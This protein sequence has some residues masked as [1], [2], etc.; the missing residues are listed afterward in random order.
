MKFAKTL[1]VASVLL[2]MANT[3]FASKIEATDEYDFN[4]ALQ[5]VFHNNV[6]SIVLVTSGGVY[7]TQDTVPM[8]I[9]K[10]LTI[11]AAPG[12]AEKPIITHSDPDSNVL[13][14]FYVCNDLTVEGV[15][16]DGGHEQCHGM[17]Y[18]LRVQH[19][20]N[21]YPGGQKFV[22]IGT[23]LRVK[24][25]DF[26]NII[27]DKQVVPE[28]NGGHALYFNRPDGQN[29]PTIKAGTIVFENC[30]FHRIGDEA[31]RLTET[32]KYPIDRV[33]DTL[34][35]RNCT[36][37]DVD[38]ECIRF[39]A[40]TDETT[41]DAYVMLENLTINNCATRV[42]Y[43]KNNFGTTFRNVI[44]TNSRLPGISRLDRTDFLVQIQRPGSHICCV[45]SF[46]ITTLDGTDEGTEIY[47]SKNQGMGVDEHTIYGF[48]PMYADAATMDYTLQAA[49][50][51]YF[52]ASDNGPLGD[53]RWATNA[54]T[55]IAFN[56]TKT[57]DG[58]VVCDPPL[59]GRSF[60][61]GTQATVTAAPDSAWTFAGWGGDLAGSDNPVTVDVN[62]A[63]NFSVTFESSSTAVADWSKNPQ[64]YKLEQN[65]PNPYNPTTTI[66]FSLEKPGSATM[67]IYDVLGKEMFTLFE[68]HFT[69]GEHEINLNASDLPTG[70]YFYKLSSGY[71][72]QVKKMIVIK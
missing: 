25:C 39:Y 38:A 67:T 1:F 21:D 52:G 46:N 61:A 17:K 36:F 3:L 45:D 6:D 57:G 59:I 4:L 30:T 35:V 56:Y 7:T 32:E 64:V 34:I 16:F 63:V 43:I 44:I 55:R 69:A 54:P 10:P 66:I 11:L 23:N 70:V 13:E 22:K 50:P 62:S 72:E 26:R 14:I 53:R 49:S 8:L 28:M 42:C 20:P 48:D 27:R 71:F 29:D 68:K 31:I 15:T 18:A 24:N 19:T 37:T 41:E 5:Y 47:V 33:A 60:P 12:L 2:L 9:E 40:D 58:S 51:A 65:Y